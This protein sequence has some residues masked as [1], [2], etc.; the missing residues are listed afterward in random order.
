MGYSMGPG[1]SPTPPTPSRLQSQKTAKTVR[2]SP[3]TRLET[4]VGGLQPPKGTYGPSSRPGLKNS[5]PRGPFRTAQRPNKGSKLSLNT[6]ANW[7][8]RPKY[9]PIL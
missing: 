8:N 2:S 9:F 5:L 3:Y 1:T 7:K 6:N 4:T